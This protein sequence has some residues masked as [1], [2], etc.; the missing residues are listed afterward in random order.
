MSD[1]AQRPRQIPLQLRLDQDATLENY[2]VSAANRALIDHLLTQL[3]AQAEPLATNRSGSGTIL[4]RF[5][6]ISAA[7]DTG[8]SHLLQALCHEADAL[9]L[10][11]LYLPLAELDQWQPDMLEGL[12]TLPVLCLDDVDALAGRGEWERALFSLYNRMAESGSLLLVSASCSPRELAV[13]LPDLASRLQSAAV[14]RLQALD[15]EDK[16]AALKMRARARGF[17]LAPE[18][19]RYLMARSTRSMQDLLTLLDRL[20][21][22]SLETGRRVTIPLLRSLMDW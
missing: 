4:E 17:E 13:A 8:R 19:L 20:D 2:H 21:L 11:A 6:W 5:C 7:A 22:H 15:D 18:V 9:N 12:E 10:P 16:M 14:F 3:R 1:A